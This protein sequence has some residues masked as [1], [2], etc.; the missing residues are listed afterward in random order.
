M[1]KTKMLTHI[2]NIKNDKQFSNLAKHS[3]NYGLSD[4]LSQILGF[5]LI[6]IYTIYLT[7]EDYGIVEITATISAFAFTLMKLGITGSVV[8]QFYDYRNNKESLKDYITTAYKLI[9]FVFP[10]IGLILL[11]FLFL[12]GDKILPGVSYWPFIVLSIVSAIFTSN[13]SLQ[14]RLIQSMNNL[15]IHYT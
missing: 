1:L 4:V 14:S 9:N 10:A 11:F 13:F 7:P 6:P 3:L 8:R 2:K 15:A 5:F 12:I